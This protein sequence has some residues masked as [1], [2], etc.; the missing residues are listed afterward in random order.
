MLRAN[1]SIGGRYGRMPKV[2]SRGEQTKKETKKY[3]SVL[4]GERWYTPAQRQ[5]P[6]VNCEI[7]STFIAAGGNELLYMGISGGK[8]AQLYAAFCP[9]PKGFD[10]V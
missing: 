7:A 9:F 2:P 5:A 1:S 10:V 8:K 4:A 6:L 3:R